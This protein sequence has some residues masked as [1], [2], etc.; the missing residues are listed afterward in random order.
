MCLIHP[1]FQF[2]GAKEFLQKRA[3]ANFSAA[4]A[5]YGKMIQQKLAKLAAV[6]TKAAKKTTAAPLNPPR[7]IPDLGS[8]L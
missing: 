7:K 8:H 3:V 6:K 1:F 5:Q 2:A 4:D